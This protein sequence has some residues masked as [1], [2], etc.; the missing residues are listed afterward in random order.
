MS[1][2]ANN[3]KVESKANGRAVVNDSPAD[4]QS[5]EVTRLSV[6]IEQVPALDPVL[7]GGKSGNFLLFISVLRT[8]FQIEAELSC[9]IFYAV[10]RYYKKDAN[11]FGP[12]TH[13]VL[14]KQMPTR[15]ARA[16]QVIRTFGHIFH[17]VI[18]LDDKYQNHRVNGI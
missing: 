10:A 2:R 11:D 13:V 17:I 15:K 18:L 6:Q 9:S 1:P 16:S 4:C 7:F 14:I 3:S 12:E 5:R 8:P